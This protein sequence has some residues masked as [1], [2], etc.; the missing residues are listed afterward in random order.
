MAILTVFEIHGDADEIMRVMGQIFSPE[1]DSLAKE[2]GAI[3]NTVARTEDGVLVVNHWENEEGMEAFG[4][5]MRPK[6]EATGVGQQVGWR[7]Y[8]VL[9]HR[10]P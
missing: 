5:I 10:V 8:E 7:M 1:S 2:H 3:S 9:Q 6:A 4:A